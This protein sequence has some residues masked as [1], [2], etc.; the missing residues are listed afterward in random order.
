MSSRS[1][2]TDAPENEMTDINIQTDIFSTRKIVEK[3]WK[4]K[5]KTKGNGHWLGIGQYEEH[6]EYS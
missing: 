1:Q 2:Q 3:K 4:K 5:L 6:I